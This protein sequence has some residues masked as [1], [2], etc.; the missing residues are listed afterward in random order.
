[1]VLEPHRLYA[2]QTVRAASFPDDK[3]TESGIS[4]LLIPSWSP[5]FTE[6]PHTND[7]ENWGEDDQQVPRTVANQCS[8]ET[9]HE[10]KNACDKRRDCEQPKRSIAWRHWAQFSLIRESVSQNRSAWASRRLAAAS[11]TFSKRSPGNGF[12][13]AWAASTAAWA[14]ELLLPAL[15]SLA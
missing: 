9:N 4:Y 12:S 15:Q 13:T 6:Y 3:T 8:S 1:M 5:I 14:H 7:H 10:H 11:A 2:S